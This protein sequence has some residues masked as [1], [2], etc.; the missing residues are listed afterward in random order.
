MKLGAGDVA[1]VTGG[2]SGIGFEL[3]RKLAQLGVSVCLTD[4]DEKAIERAVSELKGDDSQVCGIACDVTNRA[5]M[6][7]LPSKVQ[8]ELGQANLVVN[9]AGIFTPPA[10]VWEQSADFWDA[11]IDVNLMGVLNGINAFMPRFLAQDRPGYIVNIA[12]VAGHTVEPMLAPYHATKFA[13]TA[14]TESLFLELA[15]MPNEIG[16]SLVCPGFTKTSLVDNL[17]EFPGAD[18]VAGAVAEAMI[19]GVETGTTAAEVA[20][21][22]IDGVNADQFYIMTHPNSLPN[23][24]HRF[25]CILSGLNPVLKSDLASRSD[26]E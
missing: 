18:E 21:Q 17:V 13:V 8:R 2:A 9:N 19:S 24:R 1:V 23:I 5:Q 7:E 20:Q 26:P 16:V 3:S 4:I 22:V 6:A 12:S 25:D 15:A 10:R 11:A 14:V